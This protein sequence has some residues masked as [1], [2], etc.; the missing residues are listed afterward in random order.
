MKKTITVIPLSL[1]EIEEDGYHLFIEAKVNGKVVRLLVDTGASK[2]VFDKSRI[3]NLLNLNEKEPDFDTSPHLSTGLGTNTM[4]SH[5]ITIDSFKIGDLVI[6]DFEAVVLDIN[7]VNMSYDLL[8]HTGID[9]VLGSDLL[10]IYD[11][12][13]Y[14][15][16]KI[17]KL[18]F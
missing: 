7:H 5:L 17:L 10:K 16:K 6:Q 13:I 4:E 18:Y 8:G 11:A 15:K 2:T 1:F 12:V 14:Y 9:G 3:I